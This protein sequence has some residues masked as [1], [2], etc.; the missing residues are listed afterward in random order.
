MSRNEAIKWLRLNFVK[1]DSESFAAIWLVL[2]EFDIIIMHNLCFVDSDIQVQSN[3][4]RELE[5]EIF[6]DIGA[7]FHTHWREFFLGLAICN[8]VVVSENNRQS[9]K[10]ISSGSPGSV[11]SADNYG[12]EDVLVNGDQIIRDD[13][14]KHL[15]NCNSEKQINFSV[16]RSSSEEYQGSITRSNSLGTNNGNKESKTVSSPSLCMT[17]SKNPVLFG[18]QTSVSPMQFDM[19]KYEVESPDEGALVKA[20]ALYGYK[21]TGRSPNSVTITLPSGQDLVYE[22]LHILHFDSERKRMSVIVK[23]ST[24]EITLYCKGADSIVLNRLSHDQGE[25]LFCWS[26]DLVKQRLYVAIFKHVRKE[27]WQTLKSRDS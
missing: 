13:S 16:Q 1:R 25:F 23:K 12:Y 6:R 20:A 3:Q 22:I 17:Q 11:G 8:T 27:A 26:Y 9:F 7:D 24:G 15:Q 19:P 21:L 10:S 18:K 4:C 2:R 14:D 5:A